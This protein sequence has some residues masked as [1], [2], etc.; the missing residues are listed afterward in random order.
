MFEKGRIADEGT[1]NDLLKRND[2]FKA[3]WDDFIAQS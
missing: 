2:H 3:M 1:F